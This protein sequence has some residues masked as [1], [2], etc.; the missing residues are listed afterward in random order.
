M[1]TLNNRCRI[2]IGTQKGTIILTTTHIMFQG[3]ENFERKADFV[4]QQ[5]LSA[6]VFRGCLEEFVI[7]LSEGFWFICMS[8]N[9]VYIRHI[10]YTYIH[11]YLHT[12]I[13]T[14][15]CVCADLCIH[16][17]EQHVSVQF[18]EEQRPAS[19]KAEARCLT[20]S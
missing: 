9:T 10:P 20:S 12:Y 18:I 3:A 14:Y 6:E 8:V 7:H 2:I 16:R 4:G 15:M 17:D 19:R 13:H 5:G 11:T 1:G